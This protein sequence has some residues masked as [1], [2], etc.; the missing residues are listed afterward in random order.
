MKQTE[1]YNSN[2]YI[3]I[4]SQLCLK[5]ASI[6]TQNDNLELANMLAFVRSK[7]GNV[8]STLTLVF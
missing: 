8:K 3:M 4:A 7:E 5:Q 6:M 2:V 1:I